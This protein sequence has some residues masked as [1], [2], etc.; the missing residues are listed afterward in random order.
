M[1]LPAALLACTAFA[2]SAGDPQG[3]NYWK[4]TDLK[5]YAKT[6]APKLDA[7]KSANQRVGEDG[8][9]YFLMVHREGTGDS[10]L[11]ETQAD[12]FIVQSGEGTL[13]YGGQIA[14][15]KTTAP[16]EI[17]GSGITG[18]MEKPLMPGDV[19]DIPAKL[20]HWVKVAPGKQ[21]TYLVVK[22]TQ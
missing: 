12:V 22:V 5:A 11:H 16:N 9:H 6:L 19:A 10:E 18:G 15:G 13:V 1:K 17:R 14:D 8:S 4:S 20:P 3:F 21:I 7:K 2:F